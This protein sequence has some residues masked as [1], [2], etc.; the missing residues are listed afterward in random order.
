MHILLRILLV[1][2]LGILSP[3]VA[4][5]SCPGIL[6]KDEGELEKDYMLVCQG[7]R[8]AVDFFH[9]QG[10]DIKHSIKVMVHD[11][12]IKDHLEHIGLYNSAHERVDILSHRYARLLSEKT[13]PFGA[14]MDD[15]MYI[16]FATHEFAHAIAEQSFMYEPHSRVVQEY[17]AYVVQ[18]DSMGEALR[19]QIVGS[20]Q[21]AA[22]ESF[23]EVSLIYYLLDPSAF[24]VKAYK[25]FSTLDDPDKFINKLLTGEIRA[26]NQRSEWW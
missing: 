17:I 21:V 16:S 22:F 4:D 2:M 10:I 3:V 15:S 1:L 13:P 8:N 25:H 20:Y 6:L 14:Q 19:E 24:G 7:L 12:A 18:L 26:A 11:G 23:D 5:E 9:R